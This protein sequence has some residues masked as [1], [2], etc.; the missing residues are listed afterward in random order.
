MWVAGQMGHVD[1]EMVMR[2]Y[3]KWIPDNSL[4]L[5]YKLL[6]N[7]GKYFEPINPLQPRGSDNS[8]KN[9]DKS[10]TYMVEEEEAAATE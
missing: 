3:G 7:W 6:N 9:T 1:T 8:S 5:G 2:A 4:R 10:T